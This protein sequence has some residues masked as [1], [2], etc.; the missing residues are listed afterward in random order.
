MSAAL[1]DV[2]EETEVC[3]SIVQFPR[4]PAPSLLYLKLG[5]AGVS[6]A[7][8]IRRLL[9]SA[10]AAAAE[11]PSPAPGIIAVAYGD[12]EL[13]GC[14]P[15]EVVCGAARDA[16][17]AGVLVDTHSKGG[18]HLLDWIA[19]ER[20]RGVVRRARQDRLLTAIAGGLSADQ[21]EMVRWCDPEI[22]GF[23]GAACEGG[24]QGHI[25]RS[26]VFSLKEAVE[27]CS[28]GFVQDPIS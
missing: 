19:P 15:P 12:S 27:R 13:A 6:D 2:A 14:V 28:S 23:R 16:G 25:T 3:A 22:V 1:G 17:A 26:K 9:V 21:L 5:F 24:R 11:R 8:R 10:R 7:H 18:S 20:L 4:V